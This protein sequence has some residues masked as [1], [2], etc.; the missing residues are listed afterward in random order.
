MTLLLGRG[1]MPEAA[2]GGQDRPAPRLPLLGRAIQRPRLPVAGRVQGLHVPQ[3]R[4]PLPHRASQQS[5]CCGLLNPNP[6]G[7]LNPEP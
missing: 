2:G 1:S 7:L 6:D 3:G 4:P 5:G